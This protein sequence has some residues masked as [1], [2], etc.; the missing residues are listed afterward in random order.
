MTEKELRE[1]KRR[2]RPE[3]GNI[4]R[5]VGCF[6]NENKQ[7]LAHISQS[8]DFE[9]SI[10]SEKMLGVLKKSLSG[11]LGTNLSDIA[12]STRDTTES[13]EH[14]LL[15]GLVSSH[16]SDK[17]LL[18]KFYEKVIESLNFEGNYVILLANDV[19]DVFSKSS[20]GELAD[21]REVF[22]YIVCA[23]CPVKNHAEALSFRESESLFHLLSP[24]GILCAPELGFMFPTFDDRKTNI[25]NALYYTRSLEENY[26]DFVKNV[27][28]KSPK[29]PPKAQTATFGACLREGL[30]EEC[31]YDAVRAVYTHIDAMVEAHK[32]SHDPEPLL[33]TKETVKSVLS[34]YGVEQERLAE[35]ERAFDEGFGAGASITPRNALK[36]GKFEIATPSVQIK[37]DAEHRDLVSTQVIGGVKYVMI[38]AEGS[39][40]VNG[41]PIDIEE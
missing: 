3:K 34:D 40:E 2:F 12:F 29:M 24:S 4:S 33:I 5:V 6:V 36:R 35:V 23:V 17:E 20:D 1:I 30:G 28:A 39:V 41:I 8:I 22:S 21:S 37:V 31:S 13:E 25:Y 32:E 7:I 10:V 11:A 18:S 19:Y 27:F 16:L 26:A 38:R 9:D 14:A 15:R